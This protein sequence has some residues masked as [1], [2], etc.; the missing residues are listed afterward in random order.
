M[1]K[2]LS[3][4]LLSITLLVLSQAVFSQTNIPQK[5]KVISLPQSSGYNKGTLNNE[6]SI[7]KT[8]TDVVKIIKS[9]K[10]LLFIPIVIKVKA[11]DGHLFWWRINAA[12]EEKE[13]DFVILQSKA[14]DASNF[15]SKN[16][17]RKF[18]K[19]TIVCFDTLKIGAYLQKEDYSIDDYFATIDSNG[20]K[21]K[22]ALPHNVNNNLLFT[23]KI[24]NRTGV[25][26]LTLYN[27]ADTIEAITSCFI[28]MLDEQAKTSLLDVANAIKEETPDADLKTI[29]AY[30]NN[31]IRN[32]YGKASYNDIIHFLSS[33]Q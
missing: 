25:I 20:T 21:V 16:E 13:T 27:A 8:K 22:I 24:F 12:K 7:A 32:N 1:R 23:Q 5:F 14:N 17:L 18:F 9:H 26:H 2:Y 33:N 3:C 19:D 4:L 11:E 30:L 10:Q 31:Y 6:L 29:A 28:N 15:Y